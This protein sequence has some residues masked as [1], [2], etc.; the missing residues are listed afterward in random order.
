MFPDQA[1]PLCEDVLGEW[2][3]AFVVKFERSNYNEDFCNADSKV[4]QL[5]LNLDK[6]VTPIRSLDT[7]LLNKITRVSGIVSS[8]SRTISRA[9]KIHLK[10]SNCFYEIHVFSKNGQSGDSIPK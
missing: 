1:I 10:C 2:V 8:I 7:A 4:W 9:V 3:R 6:D 5:L